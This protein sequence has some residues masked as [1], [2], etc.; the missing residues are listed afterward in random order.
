[1]VAAVQ[2]S[3]TVWLLVDVADNVVLATV[4]IDTVLDVVLPT[5]LVAVTEY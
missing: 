4:A 2:L 3:P 1:L 5:L